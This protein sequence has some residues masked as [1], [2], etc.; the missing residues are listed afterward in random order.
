MR[1]LSVDWDYFF[2]S[3]E[4]LDALEAAL[5]WDWGHN[6]NWGGALNEIVWISRAAAFLTRD[7]PLPLTSGAEDSFW[8]GV[9]IAKNAQLFI[10]D[11]HV[12]AAS[13]EV[14]K[15]VTEVVNYDAHHDGGYGQDMAD[16]FKNQQVDC[17]DWTFAYVMQNARLE[18]RYPEWRLRNPEQEPTVVYSMERN[19]W[20]EGDTDQKFFHKVFICRSGSWTPPW[21]DDKFVN[22]VKSCPVFAKLRQKNLVADLLVPREW[23]QKMAEDMAKANAELLA[24]MKAAQ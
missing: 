7:L 1:L 9:R 23:S 13:L 20:A 19:Y 10:A 4:G 2:P 16:L 22:F 12:R 18:T 21:L 6:E 3:Q 11:S 5:L 17:G 24:V 8:N 14:M 15:G